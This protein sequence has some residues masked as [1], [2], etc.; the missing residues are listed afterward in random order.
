MELDHFTITRDLQ[1][2]K[3]TCRRIYPSRRNTTP[4]SAFTR[5]HFSCHT[6]VY[7][8]ALRPLTRL[9]NS[10]AIECQ[11]DAPPSFPQPAT[12]SFQPSHN[13]TQLRITC[14]A[15]LNSVYTAIVYLLL[16][17]PLLRPPL[18]YFTFLPRFPPSF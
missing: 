4:A 17:K 16:F 3:V 2:R 5:S 18:P 11:L 6:Y 1:H 9:H 8:E 15:Y 7:D 12:L 10:N 14:S 13:G